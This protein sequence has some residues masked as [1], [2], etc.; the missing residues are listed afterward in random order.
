MSHKLNTNVYKNVTKECMKE[1]YKE[2]TEK[3]RYRFG[4]KK[5]KIT[6]GKKQIERKEQ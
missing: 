1:A 2:K 5:K 4:A 3:Q 6:E